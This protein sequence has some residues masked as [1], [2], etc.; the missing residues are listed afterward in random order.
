M[1]R[2]LGLQAAEQRSR[3]TFDLAQPRPGRSQQGGIG[4][5]RIGQLLAQQPA[6]L[7]QLVELK[8]IEGEGEFGPQPGQLYSGGAIQAACGQR[9]AMDTGFAHRQ[10]HLL[11][12]PARG[13]T[14][15]LAGTT[16]G[17]QPAAEVAEQFSQAGG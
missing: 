14:P 9:R 8:L 5:D 13:H 10:H 17:P 1:V 7:G 11:Q 4:V 16:Q 2:R 15:R 3:L 6:A 12:R